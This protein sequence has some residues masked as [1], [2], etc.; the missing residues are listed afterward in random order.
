VQRTDIPEAGERSGQL[1]DSLKDPPEVWVRRYPL[2]FYFEGATRVAVGLE[3][4]A[5]FVAPLKDQA[6]RRIDLQYLAGVGDTLVG[7]HQF[8]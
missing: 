5:E 6:S 4:E 3:F 1:A 2:G 7:K 8:P